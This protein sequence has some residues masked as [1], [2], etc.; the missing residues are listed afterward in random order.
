[1]NPHTRHEVGEH[2]RPEE[3]AAYLDRAASPEERRT[4]ERHL[5]VCAECRGDLRLAAELGGARRRTTWVMIGIPM[6]AA[7]LHDVFLDGPGNRYIIDLPGRE[8]L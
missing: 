2:V 5:V 4:I 3:I 8:G 1:M 7:A 6:A